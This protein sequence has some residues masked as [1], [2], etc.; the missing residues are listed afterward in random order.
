MPRWFATR[1]PRTAPA[2]TP[3]LQRRRRRLSVLVPVLLCTVPLM[4]ADCDRGPGLSLSYGATAR[5][6]YE[7]ASVEFGDRDYE[8]AIRYADYVR[9]RFPF[10]RYAV[11][12][13]LLV[14]RSHFE[15]REYLTSKDAFKQFSKLHPTHRHV[16]N[17]WVAYMVAVSAYMAAPDAKAGILPPHYMLDQSM[18]EDALVDLEYFFDRYP[19]SDLRGN[20]EEVRDEVQRRLLAHEL[21]VAR[22]YLD[23]EFPEAAIGRLEAAS[24]RYP[25][26]GMD[27][28]ILF[29]LGVTYLRIEEIELARSTFSEL[30]TRHPEHHHGHQAKVY[31]RHIYDKYGPADPN[32]ARPDRSPPV[33][34]APPRPD[35]AELPEPSKNPKQLRLEREQK[36]QL[37]SAEPPQNPEGASP[38]AP[39]K[40]ATP[41]TP[42]AKAGGA[43][44]GSK[45]P[46]GGASTKPGTVKT[47][48]KPSSEPPKQPPAEPS[49]EPPEA[50]E[51]PEAAEQPEAGTPETSSA[52]TPQR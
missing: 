15:L 20:A 30:Q 26:V 23:R 49:A 1:A 14:A 16:R 34:I 12:A 17:G 37:E 24:R 8:E 28:D 11:E 51:Q 43:K 25:G 21:Y 5:E 13:E 41:S 9:I 19:S 22:F 39:P 40:G 4:G 2:A 29:L 48:A 44:P 35:K 33:P 45:P 47:P 52:P 32:R 38:A 36:E 46:E 18:L 3:T 6:N 10:S 42:P 50:S 31:L 27:A 7:L